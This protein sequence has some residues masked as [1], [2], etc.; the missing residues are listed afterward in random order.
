MDI[1][2]LIALKVKLEELPNDKYKTVRNELI[3]ELKRGS[4]SSIRQ[5]AD[6][7]EVNRKYSVKI[8]ISRRQFSVLNRKRFTF[9]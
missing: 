5:I 1:F 8:K 4:N 2:I 7:L 6:V 9:K 3:L